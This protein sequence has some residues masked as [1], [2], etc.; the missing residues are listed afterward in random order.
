MGQDVRLYLTHSVLA[1]VDRASMATSLEV[2][3][4]LLDTAV[5][6]FAARLPMKWKLHGLGGKYLLKRVGERLLP[7]DIVHRKK[8]GFGMPTGRWLKGPLH[9]Q[10]RSLLLGADSLAAGGRISSVEVTRLLDEH[11][12]GSVD[13]RQRLWTLL[14]LEQWR[15]AHRIAA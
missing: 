9:D 14:V 11:R 7:H 13:H 12:A 3:A 6:E 10:A 5:A 1:K 2:R 4:P 15:R 8:K